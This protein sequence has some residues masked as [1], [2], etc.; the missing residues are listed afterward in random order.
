MALDKDEKLVDK[1]FTKNEQN[2]DALM[3][4]LSISLYGTDRKNDVDALNKKFNDIMSAELHTLNRGD[5]ND[6]TSF[7]N[8]LY[9]RNQKLTNAENMLAKQFNDLNIDT[10]GLQISE[11]INERYK[12]RLMKLADIHEI[13]SQLIELR[14]AISTTR[15]AIVSA[16]V[17]TGRI[18]R[19][20]TFEN[21]TEDEK[22]DYVPIIE[23]IEEKFSIQE[24][25][26]DFIVA[27]GLEYGEY[28]VYVVP[29]SY[30]FNDFMNN[31]DKFIKSK[32]Y[33]ESGEEC[34]FLESV[35]DSNSLYIRD[36]EDE[37]ITEC[38]DIYC[39]AVATDHPNEEPYERKQRNRREKTLFTEDMNNLLSRV[40]VVGDH[41]PLNIFEDGYESCEAFRH[42]YVTEDG[43]RLMTE[44]KQE[45]DQLK[46]KSDAFTAYHKDLPKDGVFNTTD[47][48]GKDEKSNEFSDV[49]DCYIKMIDPTRL[50]PIEIMS[51]EIG[52]IYV[53]V[54]DASQLTGV[55]S[56]T[57]YYQQFEDRNKM[58]DLIDTIAARVISKFDKNFIKSNPKFKK[59]IVDCIN[60]YN[61]YE[62]QIR[63]QF[64]PKEYIIS[65]KVNKDVNGHGT[66]MLEPSLFYAKLY[67]MLLLFKM[68]SIIMNSND[69]KINYIKQSGID[70]D[71]VNKIQDIAR[72]K[73]ARNININDLFSYS[74]LINKVGNGNEIYIPVGKSGE[75]A[76]ETEILSGQEVQLNTELMELLRNSYILGTGVPS[77]IINYLNEADF[78]KSIELANSKFLG[79]V[80]NYQLDFNPGITEMYRRILKWSTNIPE[81]VIDSLHVVLPQPKNSANTATSEMIGNFTSIAEFLV[82]LYYGDSSG[83][84]RVEA[85][86]KLFKRNLAK[87]YLPMM[88][89]EEL[90]EIYNKTQ[91]ES[92]EDRLDPA[93]PLNNNDEEEMG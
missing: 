63:F 77:A 72:Q 6:T 41:I 55:L 38:Y 18:N 85:N 83:D 4:E 52:Y 57:L 89:F 70:K 78:A 88:D 27:K 91:L 36:E 45:G 81:N 3:D 46:T 87:K 82:G 54:E 61:L 86:V 60:H 67:L 17:V 8:Q 25:I 64:I 59:L 80:V 16:D 66:S 37:F 56:S 43:S 20:I 7:I 21:L 65:F 93:N 30:I 22:E 35:F 49:R 40:S 73:Q 51:E 32:M 28:Y 48:T 26:K 19:E 69:T 84:V 76:I 79:R 9:S 31:K 2:N 33:S 5:E 47:G 14:E 39:E 58:K 24:K 11:F 10:R 44:E 23:N 92:T 62:N 12:N 15:D 53:Q 50:L 34:S 42:E 90:D 75:R 1:K 29:Y 74:T 68:M 13:A 71:V